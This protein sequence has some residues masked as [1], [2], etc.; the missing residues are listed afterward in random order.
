MC[1]RDGSVY[2][3]DPNGAKHHIKYARGIYNC[4]T[5]EGESRYVFDAVEYA[6][7]VE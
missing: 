7:C 2:I 6:K 4:S 3:S 1:G 5:P